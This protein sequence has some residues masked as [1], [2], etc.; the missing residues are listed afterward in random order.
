M[1]QLESDLKQKLLD[2]DDGDKGRRAPDNSG[3]PRRLAATAM[4]RY[5]KEAA[6][7]AAEKKAAKPASTWRETDAKKSKG[8]FAS[9]MFVLPMLWKGNWWVR[10]QVILT[11]F[12][13]ILS[14]LLNVSPNPQV[15]H[16]I[17]LKFLIDDLTAGGSGYYDLLLYVLV[18]FSADICG[19]LRE[20]TFAN[21]SASAEIFIAEKV[22]KHVSDLPL[23]FH[24]ERQ[25]GKVLRVASRGSQSFA[26][27]LRYAVFVI[28]PMFLELGLVVGTIAF[29]FPWYF[30]LAMLGSVI[31]YI[32]DTFIVTE[33]RAKYFK[34]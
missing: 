3:T 26:S 28:G 12:M 34:V 4:D 2:D 20:I 18:K 30:F 8:V 14:K 21:I 24:L 5:E 10:L 23:Q 25:T 7:E 9:L 13:I 22:Y 19:N 31:L 11:A 15:A 1:A 27:L 32:L 6:R 29:I 33:W 17:C 16:P